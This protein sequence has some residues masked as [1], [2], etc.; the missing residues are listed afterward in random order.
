MNPS[1]F[2]VADDLT[3]AA[4]CAIAF[5][6]SGIPSSVLFEGNEA[7]DIPGGAV[8]VDVASRALSAEQAAKAHADLLEQ[9]FTKNT[10][11]YKKLDSLMRGQPMAETAATVAA[12]RKLG[13][14]SFVIMAPA[15]PAT[16]RTTVNG[17]VLVNGEPLEATEVWARDHTYPDGNL[18]ENLRHAGVNTYSITLDVVRSGAEQ[19]MAQVKASMDKGYNGVVCDAETLEDLAIIAQATYPLAEQVFF[20]GTGGL[21]VPLARMSSAAQGGVSI[22]LPATTRGVLMVVGSLVKVSRQA[23]RVVLDTKPVLHVPF[24]PAELASASDVA[25]EARGKEIREAL[26]AGQDVVAEIV[27][28]DDPDLSRGGILA[29]RLAVA[30]HKALEVSGGLVATGG[31]T[32]A[33][34]MARAGIHGIQ[35]VTEVESGVPVGLTL[36]QHALPVITKAGSFGSEHTL[37]RCLEYIRAA[38][39]K[40]ELA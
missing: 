6:K 35:L 8:A 36:G 26:L 37:S 10:L 27:E 28:V 25:L 3:G 15:F 4:D 16:G 21:A 31:E 38:N 39:Q 33:M 23:L 24:T 18:V 1:W 12:L 30:L 20:A 14:P 32:A 17:C 34:L 5:A 13:G 29:S 9:R 11:L 7:V 22:P 40:G 2:I 19:V